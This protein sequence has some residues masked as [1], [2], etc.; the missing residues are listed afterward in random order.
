[1]KRIANRGSRAVCSALLLLVAGCTLKPVHIQLVAFGNGD[2]DGIWLW[3]LQDSGQYARL[4]HFEISNPYPQNGVEVISYDQ[5]CSDGSPPGSPM[6]AEVVRLA[7]SPD[8]VNLRLE[9]QPGS[10]SIGTYRASAYNTS[11]ESG[12]S[13]AKI[14]L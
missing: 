10:R 4:C 5:S 6:Q 14:Q 1:M 13:S 3:R 12:L 9:Y 8:T 11:G 7:G 2:V